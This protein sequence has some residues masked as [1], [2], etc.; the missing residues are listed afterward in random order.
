MAKKAKIFK[1]PECGAELERVNVISEC[2]QKAE[3]KGDKITD[4]GSVEDILDTLY[5][6]CP[7]CQA[8]IT[9]YIKL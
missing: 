8:K 6:E 3:L 5:V 9:K 4:Y 2:W 1:C 7:E